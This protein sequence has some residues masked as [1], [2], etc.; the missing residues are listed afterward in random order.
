M[1]T[2]DHTAAEDRAERSAPTHVGR[3]AVLGLAGL[4]AAGI[5]FG[6]RIDNTVGSALTSV[7]NKLG[8]LGALIPGADNFRIYTVTG[9]I[10]T[11]SPA[12]YRLRVDGLVDHPLEL[13]IDN[14]RSMPRTNLVHYFQCVTGWRV[15]NVHWEGVKLSDILQA[16]GVRSGAKAVSLY[17]GDGVYTES[18][19][20][21]QAHLPDVLVA[22][23]MIGDDVTA[24]HGGPVRLYVAPM[25]G[26]KS[27]KWLDRIEVSD[28][29]ITGYWEEYGYPI[30]AW[31]GGQA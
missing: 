28:Q 16:A 10:P 2:Q 17:S 8:G 20:L 25:Y 3:R 27:I 6:A 30:N 13:S 22:D 9:S 21:S 18:L 29:I 12:T 14:L 15:P 19:T 5:A 4:G 23:R 24:A 11:I 1:S 26:Y 7:S 31:I